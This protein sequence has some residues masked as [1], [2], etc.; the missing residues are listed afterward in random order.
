MIGTIGPILTI[1]LGSVFL[2]EPVT[3]VQMAGAVLVIAGVAV[4]TLRR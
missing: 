4:V 2:G 3:V 1:G